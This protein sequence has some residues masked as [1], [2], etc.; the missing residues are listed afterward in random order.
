MRNIRAEV[1]SGIAIVA[2]FIILVFGYI[3]LKNVA[4]G[5]GMYEVGVRFQDASGLEVGDPVHVRGLKIGKVRRIGL[6]N[7]QIRVTLQL[8]G[9]I[10]LPKDSHIQIRDM[11][12]MGEKSIDIIPGTSGTTLQDGE[13][14]TGSVTSG[15]TDLTGSLEGLTK[16]AEELLTELQSVLKNTM[17]TDS[18]RD[19]KITLANMGDLSAKLNDNAAHVTSTMANLD[20]LSGNMDGILDR[21]RAQIEG[22]ISNVHDATADLDGTI[23]KLDKSLASLQSVMNKV[24]NAEGTVGKLISRDDL[25][26]DLSELVNELQILAQDLKQYPQ[27]Y[28]GLIKVF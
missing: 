5:A 19:L 21:R 16:Q 4:I 12:L 27:K 14:I 23:A 26:A 28:R 17:D 25:H 24:D 7:L 2:A 18:Q 13:T 20:R 8:D 15:L 6:E 1:I 11:G 9:D 10:P 22:T 3:F